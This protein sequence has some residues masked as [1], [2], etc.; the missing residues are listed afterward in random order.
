MD[1]LTDVGL[2]DSEAERQGRC[3][4]AGSVG[5]TNSNNV[6]LTKAHVVRLFAQREP[7]LLDA[8]L[9]IVG[10]RS[11]KQ[12]SRVDTRSNVAGVANQH[13]LWDWPIC[14]LPSKAVGVPDALACTE[15]ELTVAVGSQAGSPQPAAIRLADLAPE[16]LDVFRGKLWVHLRPPVSGC[17]AGGWFQQRP[18]FSFTAPIIPPL[19][20]AE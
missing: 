9:G 18:G 8:V 1:N 2:A 12:M 11:Q 17:H 6:C 4:F 13:T 19:G 3:G 14:G 20:Y 7:T 5:S 10:V 16:T 15:E